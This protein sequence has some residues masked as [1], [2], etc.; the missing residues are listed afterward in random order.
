[1]TFYAGDRYPGWKN[2]MFIA[3]MVGTQLR[4]LEIKGREV[5][6]QETV[7]N[8]VGRIRHVTVGPDGFLYLLLNQMRPPP[9]PG[10]PPVQAGAVV[11]LVPIS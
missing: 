2:N 4:R 7:I 10:Q 6:A 1:M 5:V 11:R 8:Q 3:G 9:G